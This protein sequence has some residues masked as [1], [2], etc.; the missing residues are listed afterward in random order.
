MPIENKIDKCI[1]GKSTTG[2]HMIVKLN[3]IELHQSKGKT[4]NVKWIYQVAKAYVQWS[5]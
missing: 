2:Y 1:A 4:L 5:I 3:E